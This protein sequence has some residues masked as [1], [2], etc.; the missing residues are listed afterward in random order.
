MSSRALQQRPRRRCSRG[1]RG[2]PAPTWRARR[3]PAPASA[4][5]RSGAS[6]SSAS[7]MSVMSWVMTSRPPIA[8]LAVAPGRDLDA[9]PGLR[10]VRQR[11]PGAAGADRLAGQ[12]LLE[13]IAPLAL[14]RRGRSRRSCAR[15]SPSPARPCRCASG[16]CSAAPAAC[17]RSSAA[18]PARLSITRSSTDVGGARLRFARLQRPAWRGGAPI[19]APA[20][21]ARSSSARGE[22]GV[23][24]ARF[25]VDDRERADAAAVRERD[26]RAGVEAHA[27]LAVH[28]RVVVE[29]WSAARSSIQMHRVAF[30]H[31]FRERLLA[32]H[33]GSGV[34]DTPAI[35][36]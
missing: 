33:G 24:V 13:R 4:S 34:S 3:S 7:T 32:R 35:Q 20:S 23:E 9:H 10:A 18:P 30:D 15:G 29:P 36:S 17:G 14:A 27:G 25:A 6:V 21:A 12:R 19:P 2:G 28:E 16:S 26:R 1:G 5:A 31:V 8:P 22:V 11:Q